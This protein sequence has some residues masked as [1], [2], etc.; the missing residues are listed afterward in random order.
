MLYSNS[1]A[2]FLL[3]IMQLSILIASVIAFKHS[4]YTYSCT[5]QTETNI[6]NVLADSKTF[7]YIYIY[8]Y[9]YIHTHTHTHRHTHIYIYMYIHIY[10]HTHTH[11]YIYIYIY[12][13]IHTHTYMYIYSI[14]IYTYTYINVLEAFN[15]LSRSSLTSY[16]ISRSESQ[17]NRLRF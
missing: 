13:Y 6:V 9:I 7:I 2:H 15:T 16:A 12:I 10:T 14:Y 8:I 4:I 5:V 11:I 3:L 17:M 1:L